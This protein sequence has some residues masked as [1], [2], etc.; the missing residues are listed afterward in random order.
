MKLNNTFGILL[1]TN[2][3]KWEIMLKENLNTSKGVIKSENFKYETDETILTELEPNGVKL[4]QRILRKREPRGEE[5]GTK[6]GLCNTGHLIL[7][8]E[9]RNKPD[10]VIFGSERLNVINYYPDQ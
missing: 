1:D 7:T 9:T 8:F 5:Y 3:D 6:Y 10:W 2:S 4:V